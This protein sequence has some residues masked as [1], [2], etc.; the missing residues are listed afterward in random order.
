MIAQIYQSMA[1]I[2]VSTPNLIHSV[3]M[4][5]NISR[6]DT[7]HFWSAK[8]NEAERQILFNEWETDTKTKSRY[9][10]T[11]YGISFV[12]QFWHE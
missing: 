5:F 12:I 4:V 6:E 1:E 11:F 10:K 9:T 8:Q 7:D 2:A 3:E